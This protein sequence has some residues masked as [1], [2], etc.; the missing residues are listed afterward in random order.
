MAEHA[1]IGP[2]A[3]AEA[4]HAHTPFRLSPAAAPARP[5]DP[6]SRLSA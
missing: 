6:R 5:A 4:P 1:Y 2:F 3:R